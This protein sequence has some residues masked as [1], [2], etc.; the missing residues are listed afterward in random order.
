M[1][2]I[3]VDDLTVLERLKEPGLGDLLYYD[4]YERRSGLLHLLED[5][6]EMEGTFT[7][8]ARELGLTQASVSRA[9]AGVDV[10]FHLGAQIAIPYSYVNPRDFFEVNA[11]GSL[12]VA[13]ASLAA[14]VERVIHTLFGALARPFNVT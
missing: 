14:G 8:A 7:D 6:Y 12:N 9:V 1:P 5:T 11:L 13:Q 4:A 10:V 2:A 3:T